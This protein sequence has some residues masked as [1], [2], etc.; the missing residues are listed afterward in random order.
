MGGLWLRES[1]RLLCGSAL[2]PAS[3]QRLLGGEPV[4]AVWSDP[5]YNVPVGGHVCGLGQ[6]K[7]RE[8][9][10]ASG[11]MSEREFTTFLSAYLILAKAHSLPGSLHYVC[12]DAP[13][14]LEPLTAARQAQL[15]FK[16][17]CTWAKTNAG[18]GSLYRQQTEFVH[19]FKNGGDEVAH[20]NNIQLGKY[21][22]YR[23][24]LWTYPGVN[25]FR[26]G[27]ME[28]LGHIRRSS[29]GLWWL[30]P[31][32]TAPARARACSTASAARAR[33]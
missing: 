11:E 18:M 24:T 6:V 25:T 28:N 7:H 22:R 33:R 5:P 14:A 9:A 20:I 15:A 21:G 31:S 30:M 27:R 10:T 32:R 4:R 8:F 23:T 19:V 13:Y 1:Y 26:K 12:M 16:T 2:D 17:T 29:S 3:Y